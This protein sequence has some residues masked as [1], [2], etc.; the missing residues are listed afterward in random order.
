MK[1]GGTNMTLGV[2]TTNTAALLTT[3]IAIL[4]L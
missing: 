1:T 4:I 2:S 3:A